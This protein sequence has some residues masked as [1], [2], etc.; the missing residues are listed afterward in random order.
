MSDEL[1]KPIM[2]KEDLDKFKGLIEL[3]ENPDSEPIVF[4]ALYFAILVIQCVVC[5]VMTHLLRMGIFD[6]LLFRPKC[7]VPP[8]SWMFEEPELD[9]LADLPPPPEKSKNED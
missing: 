7:I 4:E 8:F 9:Y 2:S 3:L 1:P 6:K 5:F